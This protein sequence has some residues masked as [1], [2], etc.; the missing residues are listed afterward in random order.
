MSMLI[1]VADSLHCPVIRHGIATVEA[2]LATARCQGVAAGRRCRDVNCLGIALRELGLEHHLLQS[3]LA[4]LAAK[5]TENM[6]HRELEPMSE[7][8]VHGPFP[9]KYLEETMTDS[10]SSSLFGQMYRRLPDPRAGGLRVE[11][12]EFALPAV[13]EVAADFYRDYQFIGWFIGTEENLTTRSFASN[14]RSGFERIPI[15]AEL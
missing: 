2:E 8:W 5:F 11:H 7:I 3:H 4:K 14:D 9:S 1:Q 13:F 15:G 6:R 12:P 10:Q